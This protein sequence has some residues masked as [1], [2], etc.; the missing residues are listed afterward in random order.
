[1]QKVEH[2]LKLLLRVFGAVTVI[3]L[4]HRFA[5]GVVGQDGTTSCEGE[6][7]E[8]RVPVVNVRDALPPPSNSS[9]TPRRPALEN[10]D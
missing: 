8:A 5:T 2:H 3:A 1:M 6:T 7:L 9:H 10:P 4:F